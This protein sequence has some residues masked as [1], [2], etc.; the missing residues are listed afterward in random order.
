M[1]FLNSVI[2]INDNHL[3]CSGWAIL[4]V[5][6]SLIR[7]RLYI[8]KRIFKENKL[9]RIISGFYRLLILLNITINAIFPTEEIVSIIQMLH[10]HS[11]APYGSLLL[12]INLLWVDAWAFNHFILFQFCAHLFLNFIYYFWS[13]WIYWRISI[14]NK[15]EELG[16]Y[17]SLVHSVYRYKT[18]Q[19]PQKNT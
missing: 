10:I 1:H 3:K 6:Q 5:S 11:F 14:S 8:D 18:L 12:S 15:R 13:Y 7:Y 4:N 16:G 17:F 19:I 2:Q 9:T